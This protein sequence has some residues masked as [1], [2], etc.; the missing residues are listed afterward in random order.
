MALLE[1]DY[2]RPYTGSPNVDYTEVGNA[3]GAVTKVVANL[4]SFMSG[5][6]TRLAKNISRMQQIAQETL[7]LEQAIKQEGREA[8]ADL[9]A[10][11]DAAYTRVVETVSFTLQITKDPKP[12]ETVQYAKVLDELQ[13][14][15]TPELLQVLESIKAKFSK[16]ND[17]KPA[18]LTYEPKESVSPVSEAPIFDRL[19]GFFKKYLARIQSWGQSY[20]AK[21][22]RLKASVG[23]HEN[24]SSVM[25]SV[26]PDAIA[27][28]VWQA[29]TKSKTNVVPSQKGPVGA[30]FTVH[31]DGTSYEVAVR[32]VA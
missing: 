23:L 5:K 28:V 14:H 8:I 20:D 24:R 21:L 11:E 4:S 15:L 6:Y 2:D 29:L 27:M 3:K 26:S 17:P 18:A 25:E 19:A 12:A 10:A 7:E 30:S 31:A 1:A 9:F 22:A 13:S 16:I 32:H